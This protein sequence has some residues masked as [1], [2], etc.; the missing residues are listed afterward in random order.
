MSRSSSGCESARQHAPPALPGGIWYRSV[1]VEP[2]N[3]NRSNSLTALGYGIC[4]WCHIIFQRCLLLVMSSI[5]YC[6]I[7]PINVTL[8]VPDSVTWDQSPFPLVW[9]YLEPNWLF[10]DTTPT[11]YFSCKPV[12]NFT[13]HRQLYTQFNG[14]RLKAAVDWILN[15]NIITLCP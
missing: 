4:F 12:L 7:L 11:T 13:L 3:S 10:L 2:I 6:L 9:L 14:W 15:S 8:W 1:W 5:C